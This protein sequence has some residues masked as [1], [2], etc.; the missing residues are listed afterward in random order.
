MP[1]LTKAQKAARATAAKEQA[2]AKRAT[3][4]IEHAAA[5]LN[6]TSPLC[7][8]K[9]FQWQQGPTACVAPGAWQIILP[10]VP[11]RWARCG[12]RLLRPPAQEVPG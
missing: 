7:S 10:E 5:A 4:A 9:L 2:N 8:P 6:M 3:A 11:L 1:V 12:V